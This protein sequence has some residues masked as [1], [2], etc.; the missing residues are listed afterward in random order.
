MDACIDI[1]QTSDGGFMLLGFVHSFGNGSWLIKTD[2][3]GNLEWNKTIGRAGQST[4]S[5][6]QTLDD[7]FVFVGTHYNV[8]AASE[9]IPVGRMLEGYWSHVWLAKSDE[10]GN[11]EW[12]QTYSEIPGYS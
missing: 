10:H 11:M 6:I 5:F 12:N 9:Y 1:V 3:E 8:T 2:A 7:E 4:H